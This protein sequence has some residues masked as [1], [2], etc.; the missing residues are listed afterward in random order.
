[1]VEN[2]GLASYGINYYDLGYQTGEMAVSILK[3][4]AKPADM[5]VQT[6]SIYHYA[7]N[8]T[9]AQNLELQF[10]GFAGICF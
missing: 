4:E 7:V 10:R 6:A 3:G 8:G 5:P 1:M 2:G 9:I